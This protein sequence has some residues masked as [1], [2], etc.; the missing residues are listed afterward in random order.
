MTE[1]QEQL[2]KQLTK[3]QRSV[4]IERL[5]NPTLSDAEVYKLGKGTAKGV[6]SINSSAYEILNNPAVLKFLDS[7]VEEKINSAIMSRDEMIE[8]LSHIAD[9]DISEIVEFVNRP[10]VDLEDGMQV[11]QSTVRVKDMKDLTPLQRKMIKG[12][13]QT[14]YGIELTLHDPMQ[15]KKQLAALCGYDAPVK[16][17]L[18]GPDGGAIRVANMSDEDFASELATLG[19]VKD[20]L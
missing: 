8:S 1:E 15:A 3:L 4:A 7:F 18:T 16:Q 14:K 20:G 10:G 12:I 5:N 11:W 9:A 6:D 17:Q 13:K 2:Y 19:I